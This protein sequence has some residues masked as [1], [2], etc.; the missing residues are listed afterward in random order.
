MKDRNFTLLKYVTSLLTLCAV[1]LVPFAN[2]EEQST[3][4]VG[5]K[6]VFI[7]TES[8]GSY[9]R[10]VGRLGV[11]LI[12]NS[13]PTLVRL[14]HTFRSADEIRFEVSTNRDGWLYIFHKSPTR[15]PELLWPKRSKSNLH[16]FLDDHAVRRKR[17]YLIPRDPKVFVFD[18]ELGAET[19]YI[20]ITTKKTAPRLTSQGIKME[21]PDPMSTTNVGE[22]QVVQFR[23]KGAG[24][25]G[26]AGYKGIRYI[27]TTE[28]KD[29]YVYF[30]AHPVGDN[31]NLTMIEFRLQHK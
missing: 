15:E 2:A 26:E 4:T 3:G 30:S 11:Q 7:G 9:N 25:H 23:I 29:P 5:L 6:G 31:E 1:F 8:S 16:E 21:N 22:N 13:V 17:T 19:F 18:E 27:P 28:E 10:S 20:V 12:R 14:D 24:V